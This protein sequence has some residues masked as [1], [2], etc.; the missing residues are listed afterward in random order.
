MPI[1]KISKS[2]YDSYK[3]KT[4]I[5]SV[6]E[7]EYERIKEYNKAYDRQVKNMRYALKTADGK[8]LGEVGK[9]AVEAIR[10]NTLDVYQPKTEEEKKIL[11][12]FRTKKS[13]ELLDRNGVP[14]GGEQENSKVS[15]DA[16]NAL[17]N[18]TI[19]SYTPVDEDEARIIT[20]FKRYAENVAA[21]DRINS[22]PVFARYGID[23]ANFTQKDFVKWLEDNNM[24]ATDFEKNG[25]SW[26]SKTEGGLF[27][28][29]G[30]Q[31]AS[32]QQLKDAEVLYQ[33]ASDKTSA[34]TGEWL[35]ANVGKGM[36]GFNKMV[37]A[38]ADLFLPTEFL[39]EYDF[40]SNLNEY[41]DKQLEEI[42]KYAD[43]TA[44]G[45]GVKKFTGD[46]VA[47]IVESLP[48]TVVAV[49]SGGGSVAGTA[50]TVGT[51]AAGTANAALSATKLTRAA[52]TAKAIT[53]SMAKNPSYWFSFAQTVG[54]DYENAKNNGANDMEAAFT[55]LIGSLINAGIEVGGG[56][57]DLPNNLKKGNAFRK[58]VKSSLDEGKEELLQGIV[59][60]G[61]SKAIYDSDRKA[62]SLTDENAVF[63]PITSA[64]EL[65]MGTLVGGIITGAPLGISS[66]IGKSSA[67]IDSS[68]LG[69][70]IRNNENYSKII[71]E[72]ARFAEFSNEKTL[73]A[74]ARYIQDNI[75][76]GS[77]ISN[78]KLGNFAKKAV[79]SYNTYLSRNVN[80]IS[81]S[82]G[83][84]ISKITRQNPDVSKITEVTYEFISS[85][86]SLINE[87]IIKTYVNVFSDAL[88]PSSA[89]FKALTINGKSIS[90]NIMSYISSG[91]VPTGINK[92]AFNSMM[93]KFSNILSNA[94]NEN[95][96]IHQE[97]HGE[98]AA[99]E[100]QAESIANGD[101][102]NV[103]KKASVRISLL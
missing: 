27:G 19:D 40:I 97:I 5:V 54:T 38:T 93:N 67:H 41:H 80:D 42:S 60:R 36:A 15:Y 43:R 28:I 9:D 13:I 17:L 94:I 10:N 81:K 51:A 87:K 91:V 34:G 57:E 52:S 101:Y 12:D 79:A 99:L 95:V 86:S 59:S 69:K 70:N 29:G 89:M 1:K 68:T 35:W 63:N 4:G 30:K 103:K 26:A 31:L 24:E 2:E 11:H 23:P 76:N 45:S 82:V 74:Q 46:V 71:S 39:G 16:Y 53:T 37:S 73:N 92:I 66:V 6:S 100:S 50:T 21:L 48:S 33:I 85:P 25:H 20:N 44:N 98:N 58:W 72:L 55:A 14:I 32:E 47:A 88:S 65:G 7:S 83:D 22:D 3:N 78:S 102:S 75:E 18:N 77:V 64:K 84:S 62:F 8:Y 56:I 96:R 49:M 90:D 61:L